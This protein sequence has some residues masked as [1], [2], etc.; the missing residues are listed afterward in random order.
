MLRTLFLSALCA[1][2]TPANAQLLDLGESMTIEADD[3]APVETVADRLALDVASV[4]LTADTPLTAT[5]DGVLFIP[6]ADGAAA[7]LWSVEVE[8]PP[9]TRVGLSMAEFARSDAGLVEDIVYFDSVTNDGLGPTFTIALPSVTEHLEI[10]TSGPASVTLTPLAPL[11]AADPVVGETTGLQLDAFV[12]LP[13][14]YSVP[15]E[16][17]NLRVAIALP[18]NFGVGATINVDGV[19]LLHQLDDGRPV[20]SDSMVN[21]LILRTARAS[22]FGDDPWPV[23]PLTLDLA[24]I[25]VDEVEP[26]QTLATATPL[27]WEAGDRRLRVDGRAAGGNAFD[28]WRLEHDGDG[29]L[30]I[31]L[32][33][34]GA[35]HILRLR[36]ENDA[37]LTLASAM[38]EVEIAPV[39]LPAGTYYLHVE[40]FSDRLVDYTLKLRRTRLPDAD[41]EVE[42]NDSIARGNTLRL[43]ETLTAQVWE[44]EVDYYTFTVTTPGRMWSLVSP[45]DI[46][47]ELQSPDG[48]RIAV[49]EGDG[50]SRVT[51]IPPVALPVGNYALAVT[52]VGKYELT[53]R[54]LGPVPD[55]WEAEP[56][57]RAK[58][59]NHIAI[60][61]QMRGQSADNDADH[62]YF[63]VPTAQW[64]RLQV[65]GPDDATVNVSLHYRNFEAMPGV[66]LGPGGAVDQVLWLEPGEYSVYVGRWTEGVSQDNWRVAVSTADAAGIVD[67]EP[68]SQIFRPVFAGERITGAESGLD[69]VDGYYVA[70]PDTPGRAY[71]ACTMGGG[72]LD[73]AVAPQSAKWSELEGKRAT[74]DPSQRFIDHDGTEGLAIFTRHYDRDRPGYDCG[75]HWAV[76]AALTELFA[77]LPEQPAPIAQGLVPG[78]ERFVTA[79]ATVSAAFTGSTQYQFLAFAV[80]EPGPVSLTCDGSILEGQIYDASGAGI[81]GWRRLGTSTIEAEL[82]GTNGFVGLWGHKAETDAA[83]CTLTTDGAEPANTVRLPDPI[84]RNPPIPVTGPQTFAGRVMPGELIDYHK[85]SFAFDLPAGGALLSQCTFALSD[86][87]ETVLSEALNLDNISDYTPELPQN[88]QSYTCSFLPVSALPTLPLPDTEVFVRTHNPAMPEAPEGWDVPESFA[89]GLNV[90]LSRLGGTVSAVGDAPVDDLGASLINGTSHFGGQER[91][92]D[93]KDSITFDLAGETPLPLVGLH[94]THRGRSVPISDPMR[95]ILV[96]ASTDGVNFSDVASF[97][98]SIEAVRQYLPFDAPVTATHIRIENASERCTGRFCMMMS[99]FGVIATPGV[100]PDTLPATPNI[101]DPALGGRLISATFD[102]GPRTE[103]MLF[104]DDRWWV[105][106]DEEELERPTDIVIGF[107]RDR[108]AQIDR[109]EWHLPADSVEQINPSF[110][111]LAVNS[112]LAPP[113]PIGTLNAPA[114]GEVGVLALPAGTT[115]RY[116]ILRATMTETRNWIDG[117]IKVFEAAAEEGAYLSILGTWDEDD[118]KGPTDWFN[119]A[120]PPV[121]PEKVA[122]SEASPATL[123]A[124]ALLQSVTQKEDDPDWFATPVDTSAGEEVWRVI[125]LSAPEILEVGARLYDANGAEVPMLALPEV[126]LEDERLAEAVTALETQTPDGWGDDLTLLAK[127]DPTQPYTLRVAEEARLLIMRR[128]RTD[129]LSE[130]DVTRQRA[131]AE[132]ADMLGDGADAIDIG[133]PDLNGEMLLRGHDDILLAMTRLPD[134]TGDQGIGTSDFGTAVAASAETL[135]TWPGGKTIVYFGMGGGIM[136]VEDMDWVH[137]VQDVPVRTRTVL[138][139]CNEGAFFCP[140]PVLAELNAMTFAASTGGDF[141]RTTSKSRMRA[142]LLD[143]AEAMTG[144]KPYAVSWQDMPAPPELA[145]LR[146]TL[147]EAEVEQASAEVAGPPSLAVILDASGSMLRRLDGERRIAIAQSALVDVVEN[148]VPDG[149][150]VSF[151]AFGLAPDACD[152]RNLS[153]LAPVDRGALRAAI[154]GVQAINLA[155]TPIAASIRAAAEDD[156]AEATGPRAIILLTDGEETCDGDVAGT[157]ADLQEQG[158]DITLSIVGFAIDDAALKADFDS[159]AALGNGA[160]FDAS[161]KGGLQSALG[162]ALEEVA[163]DPVPTEAEIVSLDEGGADPI[164]LAMD[165]VVELPAGRY[166]VMLDTGAALEVALVEGDALELTSADF[167]QTE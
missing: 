25:A 130:V 79:P 153:P 126:M 98:L 167:Q 117:S 42:P 133:V 35:E 144:P 149:T 160:Y 19:G 77:A 68:N 57:D 119:P 127:V 158:I 120:R 6:V 13:I 31:T 14:S 80:P 11:A 24:E 121:L 15:E 125:T 17:S 1:V 66:R 138:A 55:D 101:A 155:K 83:T 59:G 64:I 93:G 46:A 95:R 159:W 61:T 47:L 152:T 16:R 92:S 10:A 49:G 111:V 110:E 112:I 116:L 163:P 94:Y 156:L 58:D 75:F 18:A 40:T 62:V 96:S 88:A 60:G 8:A 36:D 113:V 122:S 142:A 82:P 29:A 145:S 151:R 3:A 107:W 26:N 86:G 139:P 27:P 90:A 32:D 23:V 135:R 108:L 20:A 166:R 136:G 30:E 12:E 22:A 91:V 56:N 140:D 33:G 44:R 5:V 34:P 89:G 48:V 50:T 4:P 141:V 71:Y 137:K 39:V 72:W 123:P 118:A 65:D 45:N 134:P 106:L 63:D 43:D 132:L 54:D 129:L 41:E 162:D 76:E 114:P 161:N 105:S 51:R 148:T 52:G 81:S 103:G 115:A 128:E 154:N 99:E 124:F 131:Y 165:A 9:R 150:N 38:D 100:H 143:A 37:I 69:A 146:V 74:R 102:V 21:S 109:V 7:R 157:L 164:T 2:A 53:L 104:E 87:S 78:G 84:V 28:L 73:F 85:V 97:D 67:T 147:T 70:L